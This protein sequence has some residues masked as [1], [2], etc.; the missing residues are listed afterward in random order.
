MT[1]S[2]APR[3]RGGW[4]RQGKRSRFWGQKWTQRPASVLLRC[5]YGGTTVQA[6]Y[7]KRVPR[8][9]MSRFET[10][11]PSRRV[12]GWRMKDEYRKQPQQAVW[13]TEHIPGAGP[14]EVFPDSP[15]ERWF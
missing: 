10:N 12:E 4:D 15:M 8:L 1:S 13:R 5:W 7:L 6:R 11:T 14:T 3:Q 9:P 2:G